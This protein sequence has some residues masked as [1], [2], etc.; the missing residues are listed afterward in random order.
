MAGT[1]VRG[2]KTETGFSGSSSRFATVKGVRTASENS[3]RSENIDTESGGSLKSVYI[4]VLI[5]FNRAVV[6]GVFNFR[7]SFR[8]SKHF[9]YFSIEVFRVFF[10]EWVLAPPSALTLRPSIIVL[11]SKVPQIAVNLVIFA[12]WVAKLSIPLI[13]LLLLI[14]RVTHSF[15]LCLI[16]EA[17]GSLQRLSSSRCDRYLSWADLAITSV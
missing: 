9:H 2:R 12:Q 8:I 13:N 16:L 10:Y 11:R 17:L 14:F 7:R 1:G 3:T 15:E 4:R 5:C 6:F